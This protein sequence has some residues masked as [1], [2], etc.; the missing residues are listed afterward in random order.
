VMLVL[1]LDMMFRI[2]IIV[3][4]KI[5]LFG[6]RFFVVVGEQSF[7]WR[8]ELKLVVDEKLFDQRQC[9]GIVGRHRPLLL[10][11]VPESAGAWQRRLQL[12]DKLLVVVECQR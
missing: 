8:V 12:I 1:L 11:G 10:G 4:F 9:V 7:G 2:V 6:V 5:N 3:R